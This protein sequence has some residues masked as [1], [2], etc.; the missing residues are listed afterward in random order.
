M[1]EYYK[2]IGVDPFTILPLT[3]LIKN[4]KDLEFKKFE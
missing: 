2:A 3:F 4:I 1:R